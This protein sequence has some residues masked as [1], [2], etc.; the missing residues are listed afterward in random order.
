[1][2]DLGKVP[3]EQKSPLVTQLLHVI[4][5]QIKEIQHLKEEIAR[6][7]GHKGKPKIPPS[8]LEKESEDEASKEKRSKAKRPG[9]QKRS[10]TKDLIIHETILIAPEEIAEGSTQVGHDDYIVQGLKIELYNIRYRLE[11]WCTPEGKRI[12]GELPKSVEGHFSAELRSF[13]LQQHYHCHVTQPLLL[14]EL[15]EMGVDISSGQMVT[16]Q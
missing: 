3:E 15:R 11:C 6:I 2:I 5:Q 9:S 8:G 16:S 10:K 14:E 1:M 4:D 12:K 13:A 7:K